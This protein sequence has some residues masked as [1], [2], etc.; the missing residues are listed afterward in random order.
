M[1]DHSSQVQRHPLSERGMDLYETPDVAVHVLRVDELSGSRLRPLYAAAERR[2]LGG[3]DGAI[4]C[5]DA[6]RASAERSRVTI[7]IL[8]ISSEKIALDRLCRTAA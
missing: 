6:T 2:Y 3:V 4:F 7:S 8:L 1:L 5:C